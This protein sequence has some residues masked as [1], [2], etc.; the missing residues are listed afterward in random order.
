MARRPSPIDRLQQ[1]YAGAGRPEAFELHEQQLEDP[2]ANRVIR[3]F[4]D[5][6]S[7]LGG[8]L[9]SKKDKNQLADMLSKAGYPGGLTVN[10]LQGVRMLLMLGVPVVVTLFTLTIR[11][12]FGMQSIIP[13]AYVVLFAM[14]GAMGG[15]MSLPFILRR[16][17]KKR[18]HLIQ[19]QLPDVL[20]LITIAVEAGMGFDGAM[21]RVGQRYHGAMGEELVRTNNEIRMG[22][23]W[24]DAMRDLGER[25]GVDSLRS[26]VTALLQSRELGI[27]LANVLQAQSL[28]LREERAS[29]AREQ[30]QK[31]PTKI[32][33]PLVGC[34]FPVLFI[35]LMGPAALKAMK[36]M[37]DAGVMGFHN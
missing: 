12:V 2:F 18:Q 7:H 24:N 32:L 26:L 19:R 34:I 27:N 28:R 35:V 3:P 33:F 23:P 22:R 21:D 20:D 15:Y 31:T 4:I 10:N 9:G 5:R 8:R 17:V 25:T 36:M 14:G 30:A 29:A 37:K 1:R 13:M 16:M 6:L 11:S